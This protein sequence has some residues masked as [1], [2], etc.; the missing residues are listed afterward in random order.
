MTYGDTKNNFVLKDLIGGFG[1]S[2]ANLAPPSLV[3]EEG[4]GIDKT[5]AAGEALVGRVKAL[6]AQLLVVLDRRDKLIDIN[7]RTNLHSRLAPEQL[8][9]AEAVVSND[10]WSRMKQLVK[11]K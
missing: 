6:A 1:G 11:I 4:V 3:N 2:S 8:A 5:A 7:W 9:T 10:D